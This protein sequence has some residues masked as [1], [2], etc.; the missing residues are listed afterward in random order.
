MERWGVMTCTLF[1]YSLSANL[2]TPVHPVLESF[3]TVSCPY[4]DRGPLG[5]VIK[6]WHRTQNTFSGMT[7]RR[8]IIRFWQEVTNPADK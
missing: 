5:L 2:P 8:A 7:Q 6:Q 4:G 1:D 3:R